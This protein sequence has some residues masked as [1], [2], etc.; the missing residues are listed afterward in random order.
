MN[1]TTSHGL[2]TNDLFALQII[3]EGVRTALL[4]NTVAKPS[5][6]WYFKMENSR[7]I[8]VML[9]VSTKNFCHEEFLKSYELL[10]DVPLMA[11]L[12]INYTFVNCRY[13]ADINKHALMADG[14]LNSN[15]KSILKTHGTK[16]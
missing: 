16:D 11:G 15:G 5:K 13:K 6:V 3:V 2:S 8:T 12:K 14:Y 10:G 7:F 1:T 4:K 9:I